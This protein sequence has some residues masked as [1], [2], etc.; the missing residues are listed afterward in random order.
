MS[1]FLADGSGILAD[2]YMYVYIGIA[3]NAYAQCSHNSWSSFSDEDLRACL[4]MSQ[5]AR[6]DLQDSR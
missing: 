2:L 1:H 3:G 4:K 5:D 6:R